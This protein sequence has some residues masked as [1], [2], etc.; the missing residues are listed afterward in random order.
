MDE[1]SE[2][3]KVCS[4]EFLGCL[5]T[6][7]NCFLFLDQE[8]H[9]MGLLLL[10]VMELTSLISDLTQVLYCKAQWSNKVTIFRR[11]FG[12]ITNT[13]RQDEQLNRA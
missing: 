11:I 1:D 6:K 4:E 2:K 7:V 3:G 8:C 9:V 13:F 12:D 5:L 10:E